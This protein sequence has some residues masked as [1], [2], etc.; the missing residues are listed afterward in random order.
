MIQFSINQVILL[1]NLARDPELR[2]TEQGTP[3]ATVSI[4][5][6]RSYKKGET[7][8]KQAE[9]HRL[10]IWGKMAEWASQNLTKGSKLHIEGRLQTRKW[11]KDGVD[12]YVTE[13]VVEKLTPLEK[14]GET[15]P[16]QS[17]PD[18]IPPEEDYDPS[19]EVNPDDI[20]F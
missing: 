8:E 6:S 4:A 7:W 11:T 5:T 15:K 19:Q 20:P 3:V 14:K 13:I 17:T 10:V 16:A 9:F 18:D 12:R 2:Y 1:G